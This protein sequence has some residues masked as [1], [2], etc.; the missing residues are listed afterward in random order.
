MWWGAARASQEGARASREGRSGPAGVAGRA[1]GRGMAAYV[2]G[3]AAT[4]TSPRSRPLVPSTR[5]EGGSYAFA[6]MSMAWPDFFNA[7]ECY[8]S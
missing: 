5:W 6:I 8:A 4:G 3:G 2:I 1:G 7:L